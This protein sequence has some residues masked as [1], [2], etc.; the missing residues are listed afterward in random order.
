MTDDDSLDTT[1]PPP[2]ST[3]PLSLPPRTHPP[4]LYYLPAILT[5]AQEAFIARRKSQVSNHVH[6]RIAIS[7]VP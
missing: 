1:P 3:N 5:P 4:P 2:P 6:L 7:S